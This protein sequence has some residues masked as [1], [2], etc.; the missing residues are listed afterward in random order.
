MSEVFISYARKDQVQAKAMTEAL[1]AVGF[2]VW[3]D[4]QLPTHRN[5]YDVI[6]ERLRAATAVV[7]LWSKAAADSQWVHAEADL[8]RSM[9][10]L[11]QASADGALPPMPFNQMQCAQL[12]GWRGSRDHPELQKVIDGVRA[13]S[14]PGAQDATA[15]KAGGET[16]RRRWAALV[17]GAL[18]LALVLAGAG[19]WALT[20]ASP[21]GQSDKPLI[22]VLPMRAVGGN[23]ATFSAGLTDDIAGVL[24]ENSIQIVPTAELN[25]QSA[26]QTDAR[27]LG[28]S[29]AF[30][31]S[32][33]QE[34]GHLLV[35]LYLTDVTRN[36]TVWSDEFD[37]ADTRP[38]TLRHTVSNAALEAA[39]GMLETY[40]Q[41][42]L[43]LDPQAVGLFIKGES[44][45]NGRRG[46]AEADAP[47]RAFEQV[48]A[49][50]PRFALGHSLL[51]ES[52]DGELRRAPETDRAA[53]KRQLL[54]EAE[55]GIRLAPHGASPSYDAMFG[56]A[57]VDA[58]MDIARAEDIL[59]KGIDA[60]PTYAFLQ[61]R[62]CFVLLSVGRVRDAQG[63][64]QRASALRMSAGPVSRVVAASLIEAGDIAGAR[65]VTTRA[66]DRHPDDIARWTRLDLE[67]MAGD[68]KHAEAI[69]DDPD[70]RPATLSPDAVQALRS[71][72]L[73]RTSRSPAAAALATAAIS[74]AVAR[75]GLDRRFAVL[76]PAILGRGED[77]FAALQQSPAAA[78]VNDATLLSVFLAP[79]RHDPRFWQAAARGGLITYWRKRAAW[80]DFCSA[81][82]ETFDCKAA[83]AAAQP[84]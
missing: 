57:R 51:A 25:G 7:V 60:E 76:G 36:V 39:T 69:L 74:E 12:K 35:R 20:G 58:P 4:E 9:N 53:L 8:A 79:L 5:Y 62:E 6:E 17:G 81:P 1:R 40:K 27:R 72:L 15:S 49:M 50:A 78:P 29:Y 19:Y 13:L 31:G 56:L 44:S 24:A 66:V 42:G 26:S 45:M 38:D 82:G 61:M 70:A 59:L 48:V 3:I 32:V 84:T 83:A 68:P 80:P 47:R 65:Q 34:S 2:D 37:G 22:A 21:G 18:L 64:C 28:A 33:R 10:K 23:T 43:R 41:A 30:A 52:L 63:Y 77:A 14:G 16:P 67:T 75:A 54:R 71:F 73:A 46:A 11:V 55:I